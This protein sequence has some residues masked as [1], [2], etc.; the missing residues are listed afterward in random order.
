MNNFWQRALTGAVFVGVMVGGIYLNLTFWLFLLI[1]GLG[2]WEFY[3]IMLGRGNTTTKVYGTAI[4]L[5]VYVSL[6]L[7]FTGGLHLLPFRISGRPD[8]LALLLPGFLLILL[9]ELFRKHPD[10]IKNISMAV[11]GWLYVAMP[12]ALG[13]IMDDAQR[14]T[15]YLTVNRALPFLVVVFILIW[16]N[17]TF[18]YL[19]GRLIGRTPL[20]PRISPKKTIEG[21][22]GGAVVT[23]VAAW[24]LQGY[25]LFPLNASV[26][27]TL[28]TGLTVAVMGVLG[29]LVE[30]K[31]KRQLNIKDSGNILPGHGGIL[32]RFDSFLLVVPSVY[33]LLQVAHLFVTRCN[34]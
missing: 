33:L 31:F 27:F 15:S 14:A 10:P 4:G 11:F 6:S 22:L 3:K 12:F 21:T 34:I 9:I 18:A 8:S 1:A 20:F 7:V 28:L 26:M 32:D 16:C 24:L 19:T 30:S 2:L 25:L 23:M 5:L 29:D 13:Y 17:D